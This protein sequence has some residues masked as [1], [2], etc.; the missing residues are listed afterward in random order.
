M[1]EGRDEKGRFTEKNL[2]SIARKRI[3][4]PKKYPT[5]EELAHQALEYFEW[6]GDTKNKITMAGLRLYINFSRQDW[7]NYKTQYPDYFDI[8]NTIETLLEAEWEGKLGWAG[9]TQG[10]IFWLKNKAGWKD[11]ST[12]NQV[13]TNVTASF[14][15]PIQPASESGSDSQGD[16]K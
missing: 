16:N 11:E 9:S 4:Q 8:M 5:P 15:N 3:G 1:Q 13:V 6:C 2:W 7:H 10:A 12:Q 14:G